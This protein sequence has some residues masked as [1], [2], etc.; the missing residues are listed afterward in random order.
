M[1]CTVYNYMY[2]RSCIQCNC[3]YVA[4][5]VPFSHSKLNVGHHMQC[6]RTLSSCLARECTRLGLLTEE[7][8]EEHCM[9]QSFNAGNDMQSAIPVVEARVHGHTTYT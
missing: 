6:L 7:E 5:D 3:M 9:A 4:V 2:V 1:N 8:E